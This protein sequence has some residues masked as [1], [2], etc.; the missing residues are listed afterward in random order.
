MRNYAVEEMKSFDSSAKILSKKVEL[1][2][3]YWFEVKIS[4]EIENNK[5]ALL[6][7]RT[8]MF[9]EKEKKKIFV[10]DKLIEEIEYPER[11]IV[12]NIFERFMKF[13]QL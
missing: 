4:A 2:K 5:K 1:V 3:Y 13:L 10:E 11:N 6:V 9:G 7:L 8:D 12:I